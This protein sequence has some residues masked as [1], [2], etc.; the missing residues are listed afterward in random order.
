M[1]LIFDV[2]TNTLLRSFD[3]ALANTGIVQIS[4]DGNNI[5]TINSDGDAL[6]LDG[7]T[8]EIMRSFYGEDYSIR[9]VLFSPD[10]RNFLIGTNYGN[11]TLWDTDYHDAIARA[12]SQLTR[13]L[14]PEERTQYGITDDTPTCGT[15]LT[16]AQN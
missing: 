12:C 8:G 10:G 14:T 2:E 11:V 1:I 5:I 6:I 4:S 15:L 9:N 3:Q 13:D 7:N 16:N